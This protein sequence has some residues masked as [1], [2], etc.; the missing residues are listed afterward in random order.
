MTLRSTRFYAALRA[1]CAALMLDHQ[2]ATGC[3]PA[4]NPALLRRAAILSSRRG[5]R[6]TAAGLRRV[7]AEPR[8]HAHI[9]AAVSFD[10]GAVETARPALEQ[11]ERTIRER[12]VLLPQGLARAQLLLT[13]PESPLYRPGTRETLYDAARAALLAMLPETAAPVVTDAP[14]V[15]SLTRVG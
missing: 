13:D 2:L 8:G 14:T 3:D 1:R 10:Q 7:L 5:R 11:L 4:R 9:S 12:A 6:R 15:P